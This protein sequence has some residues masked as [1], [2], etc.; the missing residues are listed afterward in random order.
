M[1][2]FVLNVVRIICW[3]KTK[4]LNSCRALLACGFS[5]GRAGNHLGNIFQYLAMAYCCKTKVVRLQLDWYHAGAFLA[6]RAFT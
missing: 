1:I 5:A 6:R 2:V 3:K 4:Q